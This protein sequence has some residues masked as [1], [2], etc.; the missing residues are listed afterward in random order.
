MNRDV[1]WNVFIS[2]ITLRENFIFKMNRTPKDAW[3]DSTVWFMVILENGTRSVVQQ[4]GFRN[5]LNLTTHLVPHVII[6]RLDAWSLL[7]CWLTLSQDSWIQF[8]LF[9]IAS[10]CLD[11]IRA[12]QLFLQTPDNFHISIKFHSNEKHLKFY[13]RTN[14]TDG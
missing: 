4:D 8:S 12:F 2:A 11:N 14:R 10:I 1:R 7:Y 3:N 6:T 13:K 5:V 9:I